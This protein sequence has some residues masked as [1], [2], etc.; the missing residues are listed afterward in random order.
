MNVDESESDADVH[1]EESDEQSDAD[2]PSLTP[3]SETSDEEVP[4][5]AKKAAGVSFSGG[6]FCTA[7]CWRRG[8]GR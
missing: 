6:A 8:R 2:G 1:E 5:G 7:R 3:V 4:V